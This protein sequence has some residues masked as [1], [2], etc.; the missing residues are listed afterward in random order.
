MWK[1]F[2]TFLTVKRKYLKKIKVHKHHPLN[3]C[4]RGIRSLVCASTKPTCYYKLLLLLLLLLETITAL[5]KVFVI[6][7]NYDIQ[8][9]N[10]YR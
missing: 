1:T 8:M 3:F 9:I 4:H 10:D 7:K 6:R 5:K 2:L